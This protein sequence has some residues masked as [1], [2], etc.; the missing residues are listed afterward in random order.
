M[1]APDSGSWR[2]PALLGQSPRFTFC[3]T[4]LLQFRRRSTLHEQNPCPGS[5]H[6]RRRRP[7]S[8]L[9]ASALS[10][11]VSVFCSGGTRRSSTATTY[12]GARPA[13]LPSSRCAGI[14]TS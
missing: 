3:C 6:Q 5:K 7:T 12:A 10:L 14:F 1:L 8:C 2:V 11:A 13:S 9:T 4:P